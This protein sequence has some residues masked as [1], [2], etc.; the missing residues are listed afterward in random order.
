MPALGL[1]S[2]ERA[3]RSSKHDCGGP[4][5][6]DY[7]FRMARLRLVIAAMVWL[8]GCFGGAWAQAGTNA[9]GVQGAAVQGGGVPGSI[10]G[11]FYKLQGFPMYTQGEPFALVETVV[12]TGKDGKGQLQTNESEEHAYR[13]GAGRFRL[14]VGVRKD[15]AFAVRRVTL[16]DP[17]ALTQ[18]TFTPG[19]TK[20]LL[21]HVGVRTPA[22]A[23]DEAKQA[24]QAVRSAEFRQTHPG[25]GSEEALPA[26]VIAGEPTVGERR[27]TV[28]PAAGGFGQTQRTVETWS[29]Q[30]LKIPLLVRVDDPFG[31][32]RVETVTELHRGEPDAALFLLPVGMVAESAVQVAGS[33]D[34]YRVGGDVKGPVVLSAAE[35]EFSEEARRKKLSGS[36]LIGLQVDA[37]GK[38]SH[39]RVIRGIGYGLD[40]KAVEAVSK[41]KFKPAMRDG[42]PVAVEVNVQVDFKT[43]LGR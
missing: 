34:L 7:S 26:R 29:S 41:Y 1:G 9:A 23:E 27:V 40:E 22:T 35:P 28:Y 21:T 31:A 12:S 37:D 6:D 4:A 33:P 32:D 17:V 24:A 15:G 19:G 38:T 3:K 8:A 36:V 2:F 43:Y 5:K 10:S 13:D 30:D 11:K 39:V 16:F 14:E 20:A 18:T 42:V 25:S